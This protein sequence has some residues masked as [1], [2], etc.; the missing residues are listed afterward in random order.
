MQASSIKHQASSIKHRLIPPDETAL[1]R[2]ADY[3]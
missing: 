3:D 1:L 2:A